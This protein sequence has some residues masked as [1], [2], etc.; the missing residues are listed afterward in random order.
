MSTSTVTPLV[1]A[2]PLGRPLPFAPHAVSVSLPAWQDNVDYQEYVP[3][4][5]DAMK[6]G[7]P[8]FFIHRSVQKLASMCERKLGQE[9][10]AML[11]PCSTY[12]NACSDFIL[13]NEPNASVRIVQFHICP[14]G[15]QSTTIS[16]P[17][18]LKKEEINRQLV[19][20]IDV[21]VVL[22]KQEQWSL[23]R[24][25]WQH[26]GMGISSRLVEQCL[27]LLDPNASNVNGSAASEESSVHGENQSHSAK[28][29]PEASSESTKRND[30]RERI[31]GLITED[32]LEPNEKT[33]PDG[34]S[35][36]RTRRVPNLSP[37][38]VFLFPSG[39]CAIWHTHQL[40]LK[41]LG[42]QK[43]VC[44]G[45]PYVD[46][47]KILQKWGP[48]CFLFGHGDEFEELEALLKTQKEAGTLSF[49]S[50]ANYEFAIVVDDTVGN[51][52][53]V[54]V[55]PYADVVCTS[56]TKVFSGAANVMAGGLILNPQGLFY[57]RLRPILE[58]SYE[59]T[60]W[61]ED[62]LVLE[63]NSRD[64]KSRV[65]KINE[66]AEAV[67]DLL[68]A[69]SFEGQ[70][71]SNC[72]PTSSLT[73]TKVP[74][75]KKIYYPKWI[76]PDLYNSFKTP[77][78][79]FGGLFSV[80]FTCDTAA[81]AF[82][83]ALGCEKGPSLGTNFT[84]ACPF[85]VLAHWAELEWARGYGVDPY[86]VRLSV[87]LEETEKVIGWIENALCAAEAAMMEQEKMVKPEV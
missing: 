53:N 45:F 37:E 29:L 23:A 67:C 78:G 19:H 54:H 27:H 11:F 6:T 48:G 76:T 52:A 61:G 56:F 40:L 69:H 4:V 21:Y 16:A 30:I 17:T 10:R 87:G 68:Y 64:F 55:L 1:A 8:R 81:V 42:D 32:V 86:L 49:L 59:D 25:F 77:K 24:A 12:A 58:S 43:S 22:F 71:P 70:N 65:Y 2:S 39:M 3:R 46:T 84:L 13:R 79:G 85:A 38:D 80:T 66:T 34:G 35:S 63:R 72:Q 50:F 44:W 9:E 18:S 83:N 14:P 15:T 5:I 82:Y 60:F 75:I 57:Q 33:Y 28:G 7:Y 20:G 74:V 51:Y 26:T 62:A 47:L 41:V 73:I 36:S 31:V